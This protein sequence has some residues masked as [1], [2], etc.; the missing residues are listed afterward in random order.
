MKKNYL[1]ISLLS[2][3]TLSGCN[4]PTTSS[5][6]SS[7]NS[8]TSTSSVSKEYWDINVLL[9]D[10]SKANDIEVQAYSN[11]NV[12]KATTDNNGVAKIE[13][14]NNP[15]DLYIYDD[16]YVLEP[17]VVLN[18]EKSTYTVSLVEVEKS[19]S[20]TGEAYN[21]Y[22]VYEGVYESSLKN[23]NVT[24][25]GFRPNRPGKY[26]VESWA[27]PLVDIDGGFYGNNDQYV[28]D[29]PSISDTNSGSYNNFSFELNIPVEEFISTGTLDSNNNPEYEKDEHGNYIPGGSYKIGIKKNSNEDANFAISIK[30]VDNY[31][32]EK[33]KAEEIHV[34]ETLTQYQDKA[35][36][37]LIYKEAALNGLTTVVYNEDDGFYHVDSLDGYVLLAKISEPCPYLDKAF[38]KTNAETGENEGI[39]GVT[40]LVVDNGQKDYSN[41]IKEYERYCN[42]DGLYPVTEELKVFLEYYYAGNKDWIGKQVEYYNPQAIDDECGWMFACGYYA[43][44]E[45]SYD[46]PFSGFGTSEDPYNIP[47]G[48]YYAKVEANSS[49]FYSHNRLN[50]LEEVT[51]FVKSSDSNAKFIV[52]EVEYGSEDGAYFEVK[53]GGLANDS[54]F[55]FE[56]TT[57]DSSAQGIVFTLGIKEDT[58]DGDKIALGKNT[59]EVLGIDAVECS[60]KAPKAGTYTVTCDEKNAMF[61]DKN[62]KIYKGNEGT[63]SFSFDLKKDEVLTFNVYTINMEQDYITFTLDCNS[64]LGTNRVEVAAYSTV[65]C[66]F[67]ASEAGT[68]EIKCGTANTAIGYE[69]KG[70]CEWK[71]GDDSDNSFTFVLE[72]NETVTFLVTTA[73]NKK[74]TVEYIITKL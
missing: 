26:V 31:V 48:E 29:N 72:E 19:K 53:V 42:S 34:T 37:E 7:L 30:W 20:G 23:N 11:G 35:S 13:K 61:E 69:E 9:P 49:V 66:I 21:P 17:G 56:V 1:L 38:S 73:N 55:T 12:K 43:N 25:F 54:F 67:K 18:S 4:T 52:N 64:K 39:L 33:V 63:I 22:I 51:I 45:D 41:F 47:V 10:G 40:G 14:D 74:G 71:Y 58:V 68:Y 57:L 46:K 44:I 6:S 27:N 5:N 16:G 50:A 8:S 36:N 62:G 70:V 65:E 15:H 60:Y 32:S 3:T 28:L 59:V 24:Y 2:I